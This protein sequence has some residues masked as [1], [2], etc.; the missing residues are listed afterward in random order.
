MGRRRSPFGTRWGRIAAIAIL[1]IPAALFLAYFILTPLLDPEMSTHMRGGGRLRLPVAWLRAGCIAA[2][3]SMLAFL[4]WQVRR[5]LIQAWRLPGRQADLLEALEAGERVLWSGRP[6]RHS[7]VGERRLMLAL[8]AIG[9]LPFAWWLWSVLSGEGSA[10]DRL[11][12][13]LIP[14]WLFCLL[15]APGL[16][17]GSGT[18]RFWIRDVF[19]MVVVT[20]RRI[21][22]IS[23]RKGA[24]YR[25][26]AGEDVLG[27]YLV[28]ANAGRGWVTVTQKAGSNVR[29]RDLRGL[30][31]PGQAV[32]AVERM[33]EI[34]SRY[35]RPVG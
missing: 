2:G 5:G 8:A 16:L 13:S 33:R 25:T 21:A 11:G 15:V 24:V 22:W 28:E 17:A 1:A 3:V 35:A 23:D 29:E 10:G 19:G 6:G 4:G 27:A 32:A 7:L 9:P 30:P 26:I 14:I 12:Y 20:D 34:V 18:M 31:E